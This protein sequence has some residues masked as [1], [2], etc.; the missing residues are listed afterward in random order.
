M[1]S[2]L[3]SLGQEMVCRCGEKMKRED[4]IRAISPLF[5]LYNYLRLG[6]AL[7]REVEEVIEKSK[8][9]KS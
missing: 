8:E 2:L 3:Y 1:S 6:Y 7:K 9:V 4:V 5:P